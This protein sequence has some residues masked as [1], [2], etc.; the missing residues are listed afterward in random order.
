MDDL[1]STLS[2]FLK[3]PE[4]MGKIQ[5]MANSLFSEN[6]KNTDGGTKNTVAEKPNIL[7]DD[8]IDISAITKIVGLLNTN[9]SDHRA[10]LLLA[11][12]PHLSD[13]RALRVDKA[14]KILKLVSL[15]PIL[16]EQ[17]MLNF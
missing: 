15:I 16:K 12:K 13:E 9:R 7:G 17:G 4:S 6:A 3:D 8:G 14:V 1:S 5:E 2:N 10:S 11:L